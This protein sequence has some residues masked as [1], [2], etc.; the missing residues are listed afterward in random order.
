MITTRW[1]TIK[2]RDFTTYIHVVWPEAQGAQKHSLN[3]NTALQ[4]RHSPSEHG[5]GHAE[6][7]LQIEPWMWRISNTRYL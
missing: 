5:K 1:I 2:T 3:C 6:K 7:T 4:V